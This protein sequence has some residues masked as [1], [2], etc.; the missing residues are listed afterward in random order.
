MINCYK[1]QFSFQNSVLSLARNCHQDLYQNFQPAQPVSKHGADIRRNATI[2]KQPQQ[3][4]YTSPISLTD[5][6]GSLAIFQIS[7]AHWLLQ[8]EHSYA[9]AVLEVVILSIHLSHAGL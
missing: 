5:F 2:R 7:H 4:A 9:S 3:T 1:P 8:R 6:T